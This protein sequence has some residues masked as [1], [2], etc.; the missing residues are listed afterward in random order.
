MQ[1]KNQFHYQGNQ[2]IDGLM[3]LSASMSDFTYDKHAHEEYS[4]GVTLKGRQDFFCR[5]QF[6][7]SPAGGVMVFNPEDVHDGQSGGTEDLEYVMLYVHPDELVS[8]FQTLGV[9]NPN[10]ARVKETL[11]SDPIL[12]QQILTLSRWM[13]ED[14]VS[15]V[16]YDAALLEVAHSII[17]MSGQAPEISV[18][19]TRRETLLQRAKAFIHANARE[20]ISIDDISHACNMSK[21][22]LIRVFKAQYG[23]TPHQYVLNCRL[24]LARRFLEL[25]KTATDIAQ[26]AGFA[27]SSHFNRRFKRVYGM[28]PAQYQKQRLS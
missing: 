7:Q 4:F 19:N 12:R 1:D 17:R 13:S 16:E 5:T 25:G 24:N 6:H 20:D 14:G 22:H 27:D 2:S 11:S 21:Y 23:M 26:I 15:T 9:V 28:T 3:L 8:H 10:Q 18:K